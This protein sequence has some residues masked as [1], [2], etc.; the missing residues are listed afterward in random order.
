MSAS[1]HAQHGHI[2]GSGTSRPEP[3]VR[4]DIVQ[5]KRQ[6]SAR[7]AQ[8]SKHPLIVELLVEQFV[9]CTHY[10]PRA[11]QRVRIRAELPPPLER[12][13]MYAERSAR[14]WLAWT[15]EPRTWFLMAQKAKVSGR[16]RRAPALRMFFYDADGRPV[17]SGT[18]VMDATRG[19]S[20]VNPH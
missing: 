7:S 20:L 1:P 14:T 11:A 8:L 15:A 4:R 13:A 12:I 2:R 9:V 3:R 5:Q 17:A 10:I 18:W 19:W 16:A 6:R